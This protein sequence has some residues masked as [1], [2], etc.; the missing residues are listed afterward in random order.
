MEPATKERNRPAA[1]GSPAWASATA[2]ASSSEA[3]V[4]L[5]PSAFFRSREPRPASSRKLDF[6]RGAAN[7]AIR[8]PRPQPRAGRTGPVIA[9][10][11]H[12]QRQQ[13]R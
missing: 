8:T 7:R 5:L 11:Q 10:R 3:E 6:S 9:D 2:R 12:D 13:G 1:N 4:V